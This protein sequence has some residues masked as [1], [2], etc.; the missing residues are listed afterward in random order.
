MRSDGDN[1]MEVDTYI[2]NSGR[3][4]MLTGADNKSGGRKPSVSEL[5]EPVFRARLEYLTPPHPAWTDG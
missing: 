4:D 2:L 1:I 5:S 3:M